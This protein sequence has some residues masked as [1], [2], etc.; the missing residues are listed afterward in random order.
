MDGWSGGDLSL[1]WS[2][3]IL[4]FSG[5]LCFLLCTIY[6]HRFLGFSPN[7]L[8]SR[9]TKEKEPMSNLFW[10]KVALFKLIVYLLKT[11]NIGDSMSKFMLLVHNVPSWMG[12]CMRNLELPPSAL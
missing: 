2:Y 1:D 3:K 10:K 12:G 4:G 6:K 11:Q 5:P 8:K 9:I 7:L